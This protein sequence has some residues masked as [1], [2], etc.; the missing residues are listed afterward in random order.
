MVAKVVNTIMFED[1][2]TQRTSLSEAHWLIYHGIDTAN[3]PDIAKQPTNT[4]A[5]REVLTEYH[6]P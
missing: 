6:H 1:S 4:A 2:L 5:A 3:K